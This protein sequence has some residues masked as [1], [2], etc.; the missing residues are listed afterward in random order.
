MTFAYLTGWRIPSEVLPL[1]WGQVD[2]KAKTIRLDPGTTKNAEG[3]TLPYDLLPD[4]CTVIDNQWTAHERLLAADAICPLVFH[5]QGDP[6]KEFRSAWQTAC[7]AA[8]VPGKIPHD[9]RRTAVRNLVRAGV[10]EHSAMKITGHK[11]RSVFDRYDIVNEADVRESLG[12]LAD[13]AGTKK[14]QSARSGRIA[15]FRKSS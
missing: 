3:R 9:F 1:K 14:G 8:G 5:R 15:R 10:P 13:G 4:L 12:K 11:T 6:I 2:R 7:E